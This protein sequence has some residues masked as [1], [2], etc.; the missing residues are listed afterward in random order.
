MPQPA[1]RVTE[2]VEP[3]QSPKTQTSMGTTT[4]YLHRAF[5]VNVHNA[6]PRCAARS[7]AA[8]GNDGVEDVAAFT[9]DEHHGWT[10]TA[11]DQRP[12]GNGT[13]PF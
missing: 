4:L 7:T 6:V 11:A 10:F 2:A 1:E 3:H 13:S 12:S 5:T 8:L 9:L